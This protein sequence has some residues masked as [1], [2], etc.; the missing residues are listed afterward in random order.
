MRSVLSFQASAP[1]R[2]ASIRTNIRTRARKHFTA[3]EKIIFTHMIEY[4]QRVCHES[5]DDIECCLAWDVVDEVTRGIRAR[6][7]WEEEVPL[8]LY[9]AEFPE[10]DECRVYDV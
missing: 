10:N 9:C 2:A 5:L 8:E 1:H 4:A 6:M 3:E 7:E